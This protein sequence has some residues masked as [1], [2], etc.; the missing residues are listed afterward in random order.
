[1]RRGGE[2]KAKEERSGVGD[3]E[4][5]GRGEGEQLGG[6]VSGDNKRVFKGEREV[7]KRKNRY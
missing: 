4:R 2:R 6:K 5:R 1:M 3:E 7:V